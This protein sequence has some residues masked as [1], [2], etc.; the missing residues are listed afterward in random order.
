MKTIFMTALLAAGAWCAQGQ[1]LDAGDIP[2]SLAAGARAVVR[3][4]DTRIEVKNLTEVVIT[5]HQV[6]TVLHPNGRYLGAM[7][8]DY[9]KAMPVTAISAA[10]YDAH[11]YMLRRYKKNDFEDVSIADGFSLF[12]DDRV[13][14]LFPDPGSYPYTVVYD[15][16]QK[17]KFTL[18]LPGWHPVTADGVSVE[19]STFSVI[20][21]RDIPLRYYQRNAPAAERDSTAKTLTYRWSLTDQRAS[22]SEEF[23]PPKFQSRMPFVALSP[24]RFS[25]YGMKGTFSDWRQY[26][27]WVFEHFLR[28]RD[29]LPEATRARVTALV[30]GAGSPQEAARRIYAFVQQRTRYVSIQVGKGGQ[31]PMEAAD[32]DRVGYGD[33][34]ALVNYTM[35]LL[36]VAGIPSYYTLVY[37][38]DEKISMLRNFASAAQGDH[39][40]LCVPFGQDTTW[41][42][43]TNQH[44]PFGYLGTFTDDRDV[45]VCTPEGGL[46][47]HT[48]RYRDSL[49]VQSRTAW[50]TLDPAGALTA[51]MTTRF[52]GLRYERRRALETMDTRERI[53][54]IR[55][56]YGYIEMNIDTLRLRFFKHALPSATEYLRFSSPNYGAP[57][58]GGMTVP[59]NP[60]DRVE[61]IPGRERHRVNDVVVMRGF[62][63]TDS[64]HFV[65]GSGRTVSMMPAA[66]HLDS[67]FGMY[68]ASVRLHGD[69]LL[70]VRRFRLNSGR[71]PPADYAKLVDFLTRVSTY[72]KQSFLVSR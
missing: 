52:E 67:P 45:V 44:V 56:L 50:L 49:N 9:D 63:T 21:P 41:L 7:V 31:V 30:A 13:K 8:L 35:A 29:E 60:L 26:G 25:Y 68:D 14:R 24:V 55:S 15:Y 34:K 54:N 6:I 66:A 59:V 1:H 3:D 62:R 48:P 42:E 53:R 2:A 28:G 64:L 71:Y 36:K 17:Y 19:R 23:K 32:V 57:A 27:A 12:Q 61:D 10:L 11:G 72:D 65:L 69:E 39:V 22:P 70:Y 18:F 58:A 47:T 5:C 4:D 37:S 46:V 40:I 16:T 38:G 33:C 20:L 43:C 51:R